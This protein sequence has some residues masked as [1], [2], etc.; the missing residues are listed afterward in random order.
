MFA[1]FVFVVALCSLPADSHVYPTPVFRFSDCHNSSLFF[2]NNSNAHVADLEV[3]CDIVELPCSVISSRQATYMTLRFDEFPSNCTY[4]TRKDNPCVFTPPC[5][6]FRILQIHDAFHNVDTI[7]CI[8][9]LKDTQFPPIRHAK[10][11]PVQQYFSN[12]TTFLYASKNSVKFSLY[13]TPQIRNLNIYAL[14]FD[15]EAYAKFIPKALLDQMNQS[16]L[17]SDQFVTVD[18]S[19]EF[20]QI[21]LNYHPNMRKYLDS[22]VFPL[23]LAVPQ[24]YNLQTSCNSS[25]PVYQQIVP[26]A[27]KM[28]YPIVNGYDD[29][30][31]RDPLII[32]PYLYCMDYFY[33]RGRSCP[34]KVNP[35]SIAGAPNFHMFTRWYIRSP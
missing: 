13:D 8:G 26:A 2:R 12:M 1:L 11:A 10:V 5:A 9:V 16:S 25:A 28:I 30:T 7:V 34:L 17:L 15:D 20:T 33:G 31:C 6:K 22:N 24:G 18:T 27:D 32:P 35:P 14:C 21:F 3:R 19:T 4:I 29:S 23:P